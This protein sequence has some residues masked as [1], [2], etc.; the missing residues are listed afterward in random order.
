MWQPRRKNK[1][2]RR[3]KYQQGHKPTKRN[4]NDPAY[5]KWRR[6]VVERDK[7]KCQYPGC[8]CKKSLQAHH[9]LPWAE[10]PALRFNVQNGITLCRK[11]HDMVWGREKDFIKIFHDILLRKLKE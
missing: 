5:K 11:H 8:S 7:R 1:T 3:R 4:Y 9:I 10:Y 6:E 2:F